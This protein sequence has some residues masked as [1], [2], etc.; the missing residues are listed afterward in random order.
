MSQCDKHNLGN[1]QSSLF[2]LVTQLNFFLSHCIGASKVL[3]DRNN[4]DQVNC[5]TSSNDKV[6]HY[7]FMHFIAQPW[8]KERI[9]R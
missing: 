1:T 9:K 2:Y 7:A 6:N 3:F 4:Y 5:L 8:K